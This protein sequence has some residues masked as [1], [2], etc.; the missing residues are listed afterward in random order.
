MQKALVVVSLCTLF[1][2][3]ACSKGKPSQKLSVEQKF[4]KSLVEDMQNNDRVSF[5]KKCVTTAEILLAQKG[6]RQSFKAKQSVA[7]SNFKSDKREQLELFETFAPKV[8]QT[9]FKAATI[10]TEPVTYFIYMDIIPHVVYAVELESGTAPFYVV[11]AEYKGV[12]KILKIV[13]K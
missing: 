9:V 4:V 12:P 10:I 7:I 1:L 3:T 8:S 11:V 6:T 5:K 13:A 2:C